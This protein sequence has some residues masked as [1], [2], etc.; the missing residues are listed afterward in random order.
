MGFDCGSAEDQLFGD[1]GGVV[2]LR[3]QTEHFAFSRSGASGHAVGVFSACSRCGII[4]VQ[5]VVGSVSRL[6]YSVRFFVVEESPLPVLPSWG[7][8]RRLRFARG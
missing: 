4:V 3:E 6:D 2:V 1:V 8:M 5:L 7:G